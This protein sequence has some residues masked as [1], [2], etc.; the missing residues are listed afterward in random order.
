VDGEHSGYRVRLAHPA[1]VRRIAGG[2][3]PW[4][5]DPGPTIAVRG[6]SIA[7]SIMIDG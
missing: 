2:P 5:P 1:P 3:Q 7:A 6:T 4:Q